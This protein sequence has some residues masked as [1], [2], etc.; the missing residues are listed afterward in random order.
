MRTLSAVAFLGLSFFLLACGLS[1]AAEPVAP[2]PTPATPS[3]RGP[4]FRENLKRW[5]ELTPAQ[6]DKLRQLY[7]RWQAATPEERE[8]F[9]AKVRHFRELTPERRQELRQRWQDYLGLS[10]EQRQKLDRLHR[11]MTRGAPGTRWG[12]AHKLHQL[13][14]EQRQQM[15]Q[16]LQALKDLPRD[17]R[18]QKAH[19]IFRRYLGLP[20]G[21]PS[22]APATP[23]PGGP[24]KRRM[25]DES[26]RHRDSSPPDSADPLLDCPWL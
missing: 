21:T 13:S 23:V 25:S 20:E 18:R 26:R 6:Q 22:T 8:A 7:H 2:S 1:L 16:E 9:R 12:A 10:P 24:H 11:F 4:R 15:R 5:L 14:P 19:D 17:Q 3:A